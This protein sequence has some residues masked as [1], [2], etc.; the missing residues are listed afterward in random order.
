MQK[1]NITYLLL[2]FL[3]QMSEKSFSMHQLTKPAIA[4]ASVQITAISPQ[5]INMIR[6][7][8]QEAPQENNTTCTTT[9]NNNNSDAIPKFEKINEQ[10]LRK[11]LKKLMTEQKNKAL[12]LKTYK[13]ENLYLKDTSCYYL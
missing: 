6:K 8:S 9:T 5:L 10:D 7:S 3:Y 13:I 4:Q 1:N 11:L 2:F 12:L